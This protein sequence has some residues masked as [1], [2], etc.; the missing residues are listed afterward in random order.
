M[1]I[2]T[3]R[4]RAKG[5]LPPQQPWPWSPPPLPQ[6]LPP[7]TPRLF[8]LAHIALGDVD[9]AATLVAAVLLRAPASEERALQ[10]LVLLV[11]QG[12]LSWPTTAGPADELRLGLKREQTDRLLSLLGQAEPSTRIGLSLHLFDDVPRDELDSLL[13][14]RG[15]EAHVEQLIIHIGESLHLIPPPG[16]QPLCV[17]LEPELLDAH[18]PQVGRLVRRHTVGC[19]ACR[20][21]AD[22]I[23][24]T[25][26][27]LRNA[28]DTFFRV[29]LP[30]DIGQR[31]TL[32]QRQQ[33]TQSK[34][35][36]VV[37]PLVLLLLVLAGR[38]WASAPDTAAAPP[39][40]SASEIVDRALH[41][42]DRHTLRYGVLHERV[43][44]GMD[45]D[46]RTLERW[47]DYSPPHRMR[48][49]VR[50]PNDVTPLFDLVTD[51]SQR[52]AYSM[53][54]WGEI[55]QGFVENEQ[56][57]DWMPLLQQL[58][59]VGGLGRSPVYQHGTDVLLLARAQRD[60]PIL[61]GTTWWRD[62][63][64]FLV[65]SVS[66]SSGRTLL[67]IDRE[68]FA[69]LEGRVNP[70]VTGT[71]TMPS[72]VVWRVELLE[73]INRPDVPGHTFRIV[74][75]GEEQPLV[76][77]RQVGLRPGP[78]LNLDLAVASNPL[79]LPK[80]L[81]EPSTLAYL[82]LP[83]RLSTSVTQVYE[84]PLST[85]IIESPLLPM[86]RLVRPL[87]EEFAAGRY[88]VVDHERENVTIL[89]WTLS[90]A[91]Q[92][93][94]RVYLWHA[95]ASDE[96]R[97]Q[98]ALRILNSMTLVDASNVHQFRDRF[99]QPD[100]SIAR[101]ERPQFMIRGGRRFVRHKLEQPERRASAAD[102][103][104]YFTR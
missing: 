43:T 17:Q 40:L 80:L 11:P 71:T 54:R 97:D 72:R 33:R 24:R 90:Q 73:M 52:L 70:R 29:P 31:M 1:N 59:M 46:A 2:A 77:P 37:V 39:A 66:A 6:T 65:M 3:L 78:L 28:L 89:D 64:A 7:Y 5:W 104:A 81:P 93:R 47:F 99:V 14:T 20:A 36:W 51:G 87:R 10:E 35:P 12:W 48:I 76:N 100:P 30:A 74:R 75:S 45:D 57:G 103:S 49:T 101:V 61:M 15:A 67:T 32:L 41:R 19:N 63:P 94:K 53:T 18:D 9:S 25:L 21:R 102:I 84:A 91:P 8:K 42:W 56:V 13:G 44:I 55:E 26:H 86:P 38:A 62:R 88:E 60:G 22:G 58:P 68:T 82:R 79:P 85:L 92:E 83:N 50:Q 23:E 27:L 34:K 98:L 96:E 95:L 69:L 4:A 16:T